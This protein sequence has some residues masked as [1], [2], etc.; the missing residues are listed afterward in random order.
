MDFKSLKIIPWAVVLV[1]LF[2]FSS[3]QAQEKYSISGQVTDANSGEVLLGATLRVAGTNLGVSTNEYGFFSL[4]LPAGNYKIQINY[5]GYNMAEQ[6]YKL[7]RNISGVNLKLSPSE[8]ALKEVE[9]TA[10]RGDENVSSVEMSTINMPIAQ[11]KKIPAFLGEVDVIKAIQLLPGVS[12]A[13]EGATGFFV[14]G[15]NLDQNLILLDEAN[16]YNAAHLFGFFSV[17]NPDAVK[18][19]KLYKGGIPAR[20][21]GRLASV[22]DVRMAEGNLNKVQGNGGIGLLSSRLTVQGPIK[23]NK[24]SFL[25]SGRRT[26]VDLFLK[27]SNN[28][29]VN[30]NT[31][32]FYDFNAKGNWIIDDKNR[33][34]LSGYFGRDIFGIQDGLAE[35]GWGNATA[36]ARW[37]H[38]FSD[39][40]FSNTTLIYAN[41]DYLLGASEG[42]NNFR[43]GSR[44]K[45]INLKYDLNYF[46][47]NN[48][49]W[50]A[51]VSSIH[52]TFKPGDIR[53]KLDSGDVFNYTITPSRAIESAAYLEREHKYN[54]WTFIYGLRYVLFQNVGQG[55]SYG[56]ENFEVVDTI[57]RKN[58][59]F[60]NS[61]HGLEPRLGASYMLNTDA[62]LKFSYN[63]MRQ[64]AQLAS[65]ATASSPL[66][67]WFLANE[68][69]KPQIADQ[70]AV[71]YFKNW[72]NNKI[73]SSVELYY[74]WMANAIDFK[75][76]ADLL[77]NQ[78]LE[79]EL[80]FGSARAYGAEFLI[81]K[82]TGRLNGF[83]AYT[84]SR[85]EKE[86]DVD[87]TLEGVEVFPAKYDKTHDISVV[88]SYE[89]N[90]KWNLNANFVYATGLA[91]TFPSGKFFYKGIAVPTYTSRNGGRF[92]AYHRLDFSAN[93]QPKSKPNQRW[94]G[95]WVFSVYNVYN[96]H[97]TYTINFKQDPQNA[98]RT[99]A[100][101]FYLFPIIPSVT[102]NFKF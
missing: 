33:V 98:N 56:L 16:V 51:G 35:I 58:G 48:D 38:I 80:R 70:V 59:E 46:A 44:I 61:Y 78:Q 86:I 67:V 57:Q 96:R 4:T 15:G 13:G 102:Y 90:D 60:Y 94:Q 97:N 31:L 18:D 84:L 6:E 85:V 87:A 81:R 5:I 14:R 66:D 62:S 30:N 100:E 1:I 20:Y 12:T 53:I 47:G 42:L 41:Y 99:I 36:T 52:H 29:A 37:N 83:I 45:D 54:R 28:E 69:I 88:L 23:K 79:A 49:T 9:I 77:L 40:L 55:V 2:A 34:Y 92:P 76:Q 91:A 82:N 11:I 39:K 27:L 93:Y 89:L 17:F 7:D 64:H 72:N 63:R 43:W 65:N 50:R 95:E 8:V 101:K 19:V 3:L 68:N 10:E 74:K 24:A 25:L 71:G 75:N 22:L 73:E 32:Y 21:G 26:Y